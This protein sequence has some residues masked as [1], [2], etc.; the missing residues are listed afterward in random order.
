MCRS[1]AQGGRKCPK[2]SDPQWISARNAHR[3]ALYQ[4]KIKNNVPLGST[5]SRF[6]KA[7]EKRIIYTPLNDEFK[8]FAIQA[9]EYAA[10]LDSTSEEARAVIGF[11][12]HT[13]FPIRDY[14]N[15]GQD[16]EKGGEKTFTPEEVEAMEKQIALLDSAIAKA[17]PVDTPRKLYRG[18]VIP[19]HIEDLNQFFEDKFT[20][21]TVFSQKSY[22]STSLNPSLAVTFSEPFTVPQNRTVIMEII[23]KNGAPLGN[24]LSAMGIK[25]Q[26]V[27]LPRNTKFKVVAIQRDVHFVWGN[28][29]PGSF[30]RD[31]K[32]T[33]IQVIAVD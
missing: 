13:F 1:A 30:D 2:H 11:T 12:S 6:G 8:E 14:L 32:R 9:D 16:M 4:A 25:E 29:E 27:L 23:S 19:N 10:M 21:G 26:E 17:A 15:G 33:I 18:M 22:M 7:G 24:D 3:R 31:V 28:S 5:D 20:P